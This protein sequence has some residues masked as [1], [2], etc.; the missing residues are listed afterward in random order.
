MV[1]SGMLPR[2]QATCMKSLEKDH[3]DLAALLLELMGLLGKSDIRWSF[4]LLDLFCAQLAAH[5]RAENVCLFP[6]ILNA[7]R[8]RYI[9]SGI[10]EPYTVRATIEKLKLDHTFFTEELAKAVKLMRQ[11]LE[12]PAGPSNQKS[13]YEAVKI[14]AEVAIRLGAHEELEEREVYRWAGL[15]LT[16]EEIARLEA[17]VE[18]ALQSLPIDHLGDQV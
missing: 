15:L 3:Q 16:A 2:T 17:A 7:P 4:E 1:E 12:A 18:T 6:A 9:E 8:E 14:V 5:I 11:L 13:I 10:L